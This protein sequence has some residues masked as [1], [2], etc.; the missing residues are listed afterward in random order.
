MNLTRAL[1][2]GWFP[3]RKRPICPL[4]SRLKP[5]GTPKPVSR[6]LARSRALPWDRPV[7]PRGYPGR[8]T[9]RRRHPVLFPNPRGKKNIWTRLAGLFVLLSTAGCGPRLGSPDRPLQ[10]EDVAAAAGIQ[11]HHTNGASGRLYLPETLGS[12][13]AFL[14]YDGDGHLDLFLVNSGPL[15]GFQG[16]GP[17][18]P[19]LCRGDGKGH[20]TDV[21][22]QAGLAFESYGIGSAVGDYDN[23]GN[24]DLYVTALGPNHLF[25]NNGNGTFTDATR[26]AGVGDPRFSSSAAWFDYDRDGKLDLFV[27][28]YVRWSPAVNVVSADPKGDRHLGGVGLYPSERSTLYRNNGDGTFTDVTGRAG[29]GNADG[30]ALGVAV[31]DFD[32]D[33][34]P[35]LVIANDMRPNR[36]YRNMGDGTFTELGQ[37]VGIAY[38]PNGEK[39]A[40][41]GVDTADEL[42]A[43][44]E[45]V[46]IGNL[47]Q[48]A[49]ALY[50][51]A[52]ASS[53][54]ALGGAG[55]AAS[56]PALGGPG[57][58]GI[59]HYEDQ[60]AAAGLREAS[61]PF[62]TFGALFADLDLDG[63]PD[64]VAANGHIDENVERLDVGVTFAERMLFFHNIGEGQY[65]ER[66]EAV[67]LKQPIL[68]RGLAL[69]D[70][71]EDGDPDLLVSTNNGAPLLL[72]NT[73]P[74]GRHWLQVRLEGTKSSRDALGSRVEIEVAGRR[75]TAWV[76]GGSSYASQSEP[77]A[78][79]GLG[80]A[81]RVDRLIVHWPRGGVETLRNLTADR[82][83]L[84]REGSG[85]VSALMAKPP[86]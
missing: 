33:G 24:P 2:L 45:S 48:Q 81:T 63:R 67:G 83:L 46:L 69:G 54:P 23:D 44:Q 38:A 60:A 77:A 64:I 66:G 78:F 8:G 73:P 43:G 18:Y 53:P 74:P 50:R 32:A 29:V 55:G 82:R 65:R 70:F 10:L 34:W 27:C 80:D 52:S 7:A 11:F 59:P 68:G 22:R 13:C 75:Q 5:A 72:R 16:H 62:L 19:A 56:P 84:I 41:M 51:P 14:D 86:P 20:F 49:L 61:L 21:T 39:R 35:D 36:L 28:N 40:G 85:L 42:G 76:R 26:R 57:G 37:A 3:G 31:C 17:F 30:A 1:A 58:A 47:S 25:H 9:R 6:A 79:F 71:D 4:A 12:G 15:P